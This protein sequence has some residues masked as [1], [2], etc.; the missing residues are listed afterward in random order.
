MIYFKRAVENN[1]LT[2]E[3]PAEIVNL[4]NLDTL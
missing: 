2:G 1:Q 3:L 4:T